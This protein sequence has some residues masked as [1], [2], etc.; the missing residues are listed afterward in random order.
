LWNILIRQD[1]K[2]RSLKA[3]F[4]I[5][6]LGRSQFKKG[7]LATERIYLDNLVGVVQ[8]FQS[9][10]SEATEDLRMLIEAFEGG[11]WYSAQLPKGKA[12]AVMMTDPDLLPVKLN[13]L[14]AYWK[15]S[16]LTTLYTRERVDLWHP[17][18]KLHI[19]DACTSHQNSFS[20][21]Q[22]LVVGDAAATYDPL[23]AQGILKA[24]SNGINAAQAITSSELNHVKL[25]QDYNA[26]LLSNFAM[27]TSEKR[28]YYN[29]ERRWE[30]TTFWKRRSG[31]YRNLVNT[32]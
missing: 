9:N 17:A 10:P 18:N 27:Y 24:I 32:V 31:D 14:E 16:L 21:Q 30:N 12:I 11:W 23:S 22:W 20:G 26:S 3:D 15:K 7:I 29:Q 19:Y 4:L 5:N 8:V 1:G 6:A 13:D 2:I 25:F 28:L